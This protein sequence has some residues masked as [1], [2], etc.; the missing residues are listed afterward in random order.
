[1]F[2]RGKYAL[3][4][5]RRE[6]RKKSF[7]A[8]S[9]LCIAVLGALAYFFFYG[10][11]I[12]FKKTP[13]NTA[14]ANETTEKVMEQKRSETSPAGADEALFSPPGASELLLLA[15]S[16]LS[17]GNCLAA[18]DYSRSLIASSKSP[19]AIKEAYEIL[20]KAASA[21]IWGD[22]SCQEKKL[23]EIRS[24]DTLTSIAKQFNTTPD[25][26]QRQNH[27][28]PDYVL[29]PGKTLLVYHG[30]WEIVVEKNDF[31]LKLMDGDAIFK[32]YLIGIG[33]QNR[34]PVGDFSVRDKQAEP[35][36]YSNGKKIPY[37][38]KENI[39]G[40]R[41]ISLSPQEGTV[42]SKGFGIHG[43]PDAEG[44]GA[45]SSNGCVRMR[46]ED[47]EELYSIVPIGTKVTVR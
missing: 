18:R 22:A 38:D 33:K 15:R 34:T 24:G 41:W 25:A 42:E 10:F 32:A 3:Q 44:L 45:A 14:P 11:G 43:T 26:I 13:T 4:G 40:S 36:W 17:D 35:A 30:N 2:Y 19:A 37:G 29:R 1:M 20:N 31:R 27:L 16:A 23:Y 12:Y 46:N 5:N 21:L 6:K 39:L 9:L 7:W 47:V 8:A 28:S